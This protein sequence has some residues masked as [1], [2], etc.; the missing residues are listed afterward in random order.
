[1]SDNFAIY[2]SNIAVGNGGPVHCLRSD[3][4]EG[5][6]SLGRDDLTIDDTIHIQGN[7]TVLGSRFTAPTVYVSSDLTVPTLFANTLELDPEGGS[8]STPFIQAPPGKANLGI[9][10]NLVLHTVYSNV[11]GAFM[12]A[13]QV[14][15]NTLSAPSKG[16]NIDSMSAVTAPT[17]FGNTAGTSATMGTIYGSTGSASAPSFTFTNRTQTGVF[18]PAANTVSVTTSGTEKMRI[19]QNGNVGFGTT[20]P[21]ANVHIVGNCNITTTANIATSLS[22]P[23]VF[24]NLSGTSAALTGDLTTGSCTSLGYMG[25]KYY[26]FNNNTTTTKQFLCRIARNGGLVELLIDDDGSSRGMGSRF[27]INVQYGALNN[28]AVSAFT[29]GYSNYTFYYEFSDPYYYLYFLENNPNF[30]FTV[31]YTVKIYSSRP[32]L[33]SIT[34]ND[35]LTGSG[36]TQIPRALTVANGVVATGG[37]LLVGDSLGI[38]TSTPQQYIDCYSAFDSTI[39]TYIPL[40]R[41]GYPSRTAKTGVTTSNNYAG[42]GGALVFSHDLTNETVNRA[43]VIASVDENQNY[44]QNI[45]MR[46]LTTYGY[47]TTLSEKMRLTSQGYLGVGTTTP[48]QMLHVNGNMRLGPSGHV[49]SQYSLTCGGQL[50]ILANDTGTDANNYEL[51]LKTGNY[52]GV[53]CI[54]NTLGVRLNTNATAW[55]SLSD[56]RT[57][58]DV[59]EYQPCLNK[60]MQLRPV[61]YRFTSEEE[62]SRLRPGLIAQEVSGVFDE[63]VDEYTSEEYPDGVYTLRYSDAVP[64]LIKSIQELNDKVQQQASFI[65]SLESRLV[66]LEGKNT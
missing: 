3:A 37:T 55:S 2:S 21:L 40:L 31:Y 35:G 39:N 63:L 47:G 66:A 4:V 61:M 17:F 54:A 36:A 32:T 10:S 26:S 14:T 50:L 64:I 16:S 29:G 8:L 33:T 22:A 25:T 12:T 19:D 62:T 1:M 15:T 27:I 46:F 60:L 48:E 52:G 51:V 34:A 5:I 30:S 28:H 38:G 18:S 13:N 41:L 42:A 58:K 49:N 6:L 23:T 45:G 20:T 44:G 56:A 24:A 59:E 57:K 53:S 11:S 65:S 43:A 7:L 9:L